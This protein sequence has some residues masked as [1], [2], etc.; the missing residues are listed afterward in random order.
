MA[1]EAIG[2]MSP[3]D[4][5]MVLDAVRVLKASGLLSTSGLKKAYN[6][7]P[8][9]P[10]Y[11]TNVSGETIPAYACMQVTG[12]QEVGPQNFFKVAKP[13]DEYGFAGA[14]IFNTHRDIDTGGQGIATAGVDARSL[15]ENPAAS[16]GSRLRPRVNTW[17][18]YT[19]TGG[20]FIA[21]GPDDIASSV[22]RIFVSSAAICSQI[23]F[24]ITGTVSSNSY[25]ATVLEHTTG[26]EDVP[27]VSGCSVTVEENMECLTVEE[28][29]HG[30]ATWVQDCGVSPPV[31][32]WSI[33]SL[34]CPE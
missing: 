21:G 7:P 10:L 6:P 9:T 26:F 20:M 8:N 30:W 31:G 25:S 14:F 23:H 28:G 11:V 16:S 13:A 5:R 19:D 22:Q 12:T 34:C 1:A 4:T 29:M 18:I 15:S 3:D 32:K 2:A 17:K 27:G 24:V 33:H